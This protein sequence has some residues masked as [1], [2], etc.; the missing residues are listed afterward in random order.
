MHAFAQVQIHLTEADRAVS[1]LQT[2][3]EGIDT[4]LDLV[5]SRSQTAQKALH[6]AEARLGALESEEQE[7]GVKRA[8]AAERLRTLGD[9]TAVLTASLE[10]LRNKQQKLQTR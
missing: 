9:R 8:A 6:T 7:L 2:E 4:A 1:V 10:Q 3:K 5:Q